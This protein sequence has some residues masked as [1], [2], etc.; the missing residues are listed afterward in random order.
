MNAL[1]ITLAADN[2]VNL[3]LAY[4][5][6]IQG[7]LYADWKKLWPSLHDAG[8][9]DGERHFR[10]FTF[11][12]LTG[13]S[14]VK[15]KTITFRNLIHLEVRSPVAELTEALRDLYKD[16]VLQSLVYLSAQHHLLAHQHPLS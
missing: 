15:D 6:L 7:A 4:N 1:K 3:P 8:Y 12:P 11:G 10:L 9:M 14:F 5:Y 13:N 16:Q 2:P